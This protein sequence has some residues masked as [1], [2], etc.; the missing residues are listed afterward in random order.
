M[1]TS[2]TN[3][4]SSRGRQRKAKVK[5][6]LL[7][8]DYDALAEWYKIERTAVR[9]LSSMLFDPDRLI[10]MRAAEALGR[11]AAREYKQDPERVYPASAPAVLAVKRRIWQSR[12]V[13][14]SRR[15]PKYWQT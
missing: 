12:L 10:C 9:T 11:V 1:N 4:K 14:P 2:E 3:H 7:K 6:I 13:R 5:E 15:L 8:R